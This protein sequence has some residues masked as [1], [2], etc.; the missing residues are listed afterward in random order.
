MHWYGSASDLL[1]GPIGNGL[2]TLSLSLAQS[3]TT[4]LGGSVANSYSGGTTISGGTVQLGGP[5]ALGNAG[6]LS[7]NGSV[8]N[9]NGFSATAGLFSGGP[10]TILNNSGSGVSI[11]TINQGSSSPSN[12]S[13]T[14]ADND[15][16]HTGGSVAVNIAGGGEVTLTGTSTTAAAVRQSAAPRRSTSSAAPPLAR[17]G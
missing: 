11:L 10:G 2:G 14:I 1:S 4:L 17:V 16:V 13:G 9:L 8:L 12:F 15:G 5:N 6:P 3:G 7:I